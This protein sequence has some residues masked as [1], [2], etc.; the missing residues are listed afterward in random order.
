VVPGRDAFGNEIGEAGAPASTPDGAPDLGGFAPPLAPTP[1]PG[2]TAAAPAQRHVI[3]AGHPL[4]G[5]APA[6][7]A[8][9][10]APGAMLI[11]AL[12]VVSV[13]VFPLAPFAWWQG[14]VL[15]RRIAG[16][17]GRLGG[18][19]LAAIAQLLGLL[20]TCILVLYVISVIGQLG[21]HGH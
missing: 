16:S 2:P 13:L 11:L 8:A 18:S 20:G 6:P 21:G 17:G 12:S 19:G 1:K 10:L 3:A 15:T 9:E 7:A 4:S 14:R 5:G